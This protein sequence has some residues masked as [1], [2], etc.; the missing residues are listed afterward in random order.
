MNSTT[1][2]WAI[3]IIIV[4]LAVYLLPS[5]IAEQRHHRE[6]RAILALNVLLGWTFIGWCIAFIWALT[7]NVEPPPPSLEDRAA[8]RE[9]AAQELRVL[10]A[11]RAALETEAATPIPPV[12]TDD[13]AHV[14]KI[15][16][17]AQELMHIENERRRS[18]G[19]LPLSLDQPARRPGP[20]SD[21]TQE[22]KLHAAA[23]ELLRLENERR[24]A[25]GLPPLWPDTSRS[26]AS[27]S[28]LPEGPH[29][30]RRLRVVPKPR[31]GPNVM[32]QPRKGSKSPFIVG[33]GNVDILCGTCDSILAKG[34]SDDYAP[35]VVF[36]C[37]DCGSYNHGAAT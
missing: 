9:A 33:R 12:T 1:I 3:A 8:Q 27:E 37:P 24:A 26:M 4:A 21:P 31:E 36:R 23:D 5:V 14:A 2:V 10:Q 30:R 6:R 20:H 13:P 19:L 16:T 25:G 11:E 7:S 22:W 34:V 15:R 29:S 17:A 32:L 18:A 35:D 28:S